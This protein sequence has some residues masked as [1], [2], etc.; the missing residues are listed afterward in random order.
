[1]HYA[2]FHGLVILDKVCTSSNK[3]RNPQGGVACSVFCVALQNGNTCDTYTGH[4]VLQFN[5]RSAIQCRKYSISGHAKRQVCVYTGLV[6][7]AFCTF[8]KTQTTWNPDI[9]SNVIDIII[10]NCFSDGENTN[11]KTNT[12]APEKGWLLMQYSGECTC[13]Q[14]LLATVFSI[15]AFLCCSIQSEYFFLQQYSLLL[16][17]YAEVSSLS[18]FSSNSIQRCCIYMLL[19][20]SVS[21]TR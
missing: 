7:D 15:A 13:S 1:M 6:C 4:P 12:S 20:Y 2:F 16:Q 17:F 18:I 3:N 9:Q 19:Q 5:T 10:G 11:T 8:F 14:L 21:C